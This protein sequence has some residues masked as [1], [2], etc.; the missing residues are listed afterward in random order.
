MTK[1]RLSPVLL[2]DGNHQVLSRKFELH[3]KTGNLIEFAKRLKV[4]DVDEI[5]V[6][7]I[8]SNYDSDRHDATTQKRFC[9]IIREVSQDCF[10]PL[11]AGG[12]IDSVASIDDA[13]RAGADRVIINSA[14]Y[15]NIELIRQA[16]A[17]FGSQAIIGGIDVRKKGCAFKTYSAAGKKEQPL[18][19][20]EWATQLQDAG[21]GEILL[22][23]I[24]DDGA[25][26]GFNLEL[27]KSICEALRVPV[28][29]LGGAGC[30]NDFKS[31]IEAGASA[32]AASNLFV[33]KELSYANIKTELSKNL[34]TRDCN[35]F[36]F[37]AVRQM[38]EQENTAESKE[39][40]LW[41]LL[42]GTGLME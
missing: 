1:M 25:G 27:I 11:V 12:G 6:L 4:W 32:A 3:Q 10:A 29:A 41:N 19:P 31:A 22:Q 14:A 13:V 37:H 21:V 23:S 17:V 39:K 20:L 5:I 2:W 40:S 26:A 36:D 33:F 7:N 38:A 15:S 30:P 35:L 8:A 28:V 9:Q 24:D 16:S 18:S 34:D 42:D